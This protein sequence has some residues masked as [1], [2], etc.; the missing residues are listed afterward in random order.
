MPHELHIPTE[1]DLAA[2]ISKE[3]HDLKSPFNR[4]LGFLKLVLD[5]FSGP[6]PEQ[7][8]KDLTIAYQNTLY[9]LMMLDALVDV[10]RLGRGESDLTLDAHSVNFILQKTISEWKRKYHKENPVEITYSASQTH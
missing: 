9:S 2:F 4:A 10:A 7:V 3:A 6:I 5:G 1:I 8:G